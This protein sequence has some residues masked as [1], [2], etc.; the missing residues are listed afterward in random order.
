MYI[1]NSFNKT[2]TKKVLLIVDFNTKKNR[3]F[4]NGRKKMF[5]LLGIDFKG[6]IVIL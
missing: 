1:I 5:F 4:L 3:L 6:N 2:F